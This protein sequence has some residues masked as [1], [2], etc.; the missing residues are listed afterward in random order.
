MQNFVYVVGSRATREV[1]LV[2]PA[3]DI[4]GL[5]AHLA[6]RDY[7]LTGALVTHYH[8]DHIGGGFSGR[9]IRRPCGTVGEASGEDLCAQRRSRR[10]AQSDRRFGDAISS[11]SIRATN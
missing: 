2:D 10:R 7:K 5:S 9:K 4:D 11:K 1:V 8:P 6:E 3:W